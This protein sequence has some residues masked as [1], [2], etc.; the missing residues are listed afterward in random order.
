MSILVKGTIKKEEQPI[1]NININATNNAKRL[2][3]K[4]KQV[5]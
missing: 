2:I 1:I 4:K 5:I 3:K